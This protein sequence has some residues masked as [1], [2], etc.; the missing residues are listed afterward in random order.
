[1]NK[2]KMLYY[3]WISVSEGIDVN[4]TSLSIECVTYLSLLIFLDKGLSFNQMLQSLSWCIDDVYVTILNIHGADYC[5]II[6]RIGKNE[7]VN[8]LQNTIFTEKK[9]NIIKHKNLLRI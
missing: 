6:N 9:W 3:D 4:K 5:C 7:S 2:I 1:M 8:L